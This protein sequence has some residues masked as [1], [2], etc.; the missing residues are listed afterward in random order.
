MLQKR[1]KT[2]IP[3]LD[4]LVGG[5][6]VEGS[7]VLMSGG[8]GSGKTLFGAQFLWEGVQNGESGLFITLEERPEDIKGDA[9]AFGW[10]F[11]KYEKKNLFRIIYHD[12]SQVSNLSST[13]VNEISDLKAKRLVIDSA[14]VLGMTMDSKAEIRRRLINII[15]T[16]KR[17]K[18]ITAILTSEVPEGTKHL[19]LFGVEE[20]VADAV[21]LITY[22]GAGEATGR[23]LQVRKMRRTNHGKDIYPLLIDTKGL[24]VKK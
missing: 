7:V 11:E 23:T 3:G 20:Y 13:I 19:S 4:S 1:I 21:I 15:N 22:V 12:P 24:V 2:G 14:T 5:G 6:F 18:G 10:D 9:L 16:I 8:T 17:R